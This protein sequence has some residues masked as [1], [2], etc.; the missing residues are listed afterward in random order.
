MKVVAAAVDVSKSVTQPRIARYQMLALISAFLGWMFDSM[1]LNLFTLILFPSVSELIHNVN[2]A[3]VSRIGGLIMAIKLF[4]WGIGG[5]LFGVAADRYGR[6][7]IMGLTIL[8]YSVFTGLSAFAQNWQELALFQ[9]LAGFG[10]GGEWAA[11]AALVA[12]TWPTKY[13]ARA[14]QIMQMA[15]AFG[16][17]AAALDNLILGTHGWRWVIAAGALPAILTVFVRRFVPEPEKWIKVKEAESLPGAER[18]SAVGTFKEIF[19]NGLRRRTIVGVVVASAA[20]IG[21]WGG[22]TLLPSWM[23]QLSSTAPDLNPKDA[24]SYAFMLMMAGATLGYITLIYLSDVLGRRWCY[25][26]FWT[27]ALFTSLYLFTYVHTLYEVLWFMPVYGYFVIGGFGTFA[28]YLPELFP[29]R[30]RATGQGFCWNMARAI[31]GIGPLMIGVLVM[32][33][34]SLPNAA[35]VISLFIVVGLIAIWFGPET[36]GMPLED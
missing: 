11:G 18:V 24:V 21:C 34:G 4:A 27:A 1:D 7:R 20:M 10:I 3:E 16:F 32:R 26:L 5:M 2:P 13:R 31:T 30:V 36:K 14:I 33:F 25:F 8:I 22:L 6:A 9:A 12:E 15:F 17:F 23:Q 19:K 29:T 35:A 28:T